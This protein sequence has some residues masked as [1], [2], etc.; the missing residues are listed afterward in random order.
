MTLDQAQSCID[1]LPVI[2]GYVYSIEYDDDLNPYVLVTGPN[3]WVCMFANV[4]Y[5]TWAIKAI[6]DHAAS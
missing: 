6:E 2:S 5:L 4:Q 1:Q 3:E